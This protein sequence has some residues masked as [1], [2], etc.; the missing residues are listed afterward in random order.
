MLVYTLYIARSE[1][2]PCC[3][4]SC[5]LLQLDTLFSLQIY[6]TTTKRAW[7]SFSSKWLFSVVGSSNIKSAYTNLCPLLWSPLSSCQL[8]FL[9][10]VICIGQVQVKLVSNSTSDGVIRVVEYI[11]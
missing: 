10:C 5:A 6:R 7:L 3:S 9:C 8:G 4:L 2:A 1:N 11:E